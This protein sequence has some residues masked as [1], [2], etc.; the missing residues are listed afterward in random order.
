MSSILIRAK[1][2]PV[3]VIDIW[4]SVSEIPSKLRYGI[5]AL[6]RSSFQ[7]SYINLVI[8]KSIKQELVEN[9]NVDSQKVLV[10]NYRISDIFNRMYQMI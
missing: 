8:S 4:Y 6:L 7:A 1:F 9:Y 5:N 10:Y 2:I 3:I